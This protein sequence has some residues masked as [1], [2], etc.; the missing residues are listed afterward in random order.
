VS[1]GPEWNLRNSEPRRVVQVPT[2]K[3]SLDTELKWSSFGFCSSHGDQDVNARRESTQCESQ[4][5]RHCRRVVS[6]D[7]LQLSA[8]SATP[9]QVSLAMSFRQAP[10]VKSHNS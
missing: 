2:T 3:Q 8:N 4:R 7:I 6:Y 1:P 9:R 10:A 5:S